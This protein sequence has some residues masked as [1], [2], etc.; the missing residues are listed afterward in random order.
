MLFASY[1]M[2][3]SNQEMMDRFGDS[4]R[5]DKIRFYMFVLSLRLLTLNGKGSK[6]SYLDVKEL[7]DFE[8]EQ[9]V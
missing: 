7:S 9:I 4:L 2:C 1:E 3:V 8:D 5:Y 6:T